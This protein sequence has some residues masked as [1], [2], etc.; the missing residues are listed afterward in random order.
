MS[1]NYTP[2]VEE[3]NISFPILLRQ[4]LL[5]S[6]KNEK[7]YLSAITFSMVTYFCIAKQ[8]KHLLKMLDDNVDKIL[9]DCEIYFNMDKEKAI[10][11][12]KEL[13]NLASIYVEH[14][15]PQIYQRI[16]HLIQQIRV[17]YPL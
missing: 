8:P 17:S 13:S 2:T 6:R 10:D 1:D 12:M 3:C 4:R 14:E 5:Y 9:D 7:L 16:C 11:A 15:K